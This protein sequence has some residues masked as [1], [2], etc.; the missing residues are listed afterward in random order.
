MKEKWNWKTSLNPG[1]IW[2][3]VSCTHWGTEHRC[4]EGS[5]YV[6]L[7]LVFPMPDMKRK[8]SFTVKSSPP[9]AVSELITGGLSC[10]LF[11]AGYWQDSLHL[12]EPKILLCIH[13]NR[14]VSSSSPTHLSEK[15]LFTGEVFCVRI[16]LLLPFSFPFFTLRY[17]LPFTSSCHL[18]SLPPC[19]SGL[20]LPLCLGTIHPFN[21]TAFPK[22]FLSALPLAWR[23]T[24]ICSTESQWLSKV[25][26]HA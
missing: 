8:A 17:K 23:Q 18:L 21:E 13:E 24:C 14:T 22:G 5:D 19:L 26:I 10:C 6:S 20:L 15:V 25:K 16:L 4:K 12:V 3:E 1:S 2:L 7:I 11:L 9:A